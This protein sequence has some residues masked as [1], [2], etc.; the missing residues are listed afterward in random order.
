MASALLDL[1][2]EILAVGTKK[3]SHEDEEKVRTILGPDVRLIEDISPAVI[4]R[5]FAE[6]GADLLVAG[7]R[8]RYLAAKEGWPFIDVNQ[9]REHAYA[10]YEGLVQVARDLHESVRFYEAQA[11]A[12]VDCPAPAQPTPV[13]T[14]DRS[15]VIDPLKNAPTVGAILALQGI[16][17][18][19]P[20]LHAAQG[21][22]FLGKVLMIR[23]FNEPIALATTKLF[24]EEV[25][26][27][28]DEAAE[29][30]V[31]SFAEKPA[32]QR[33]ELIALVSGA[34]AEVKGDDVDALA[35]RLD[36]E[37]DPQGRRDSRA[38][39]TTVASKRATPPQSH[40]LAGLA[41]DVEPAATPR[42]RPHH[43]P[44]GAHLTP[45]DAVWLARARRGVRPAAGV[46]ARTWAPSTAAELGLSALASD[47]TSL[48]EIHGTRVQLTHARAR[49]LARG[50]RACAARAFRHAVLGARDARTVSPPPTCC[51][52]RSRCSPAPRCRCASSASAACSSTPCAT[53]SSNS[54]ARR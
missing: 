33:P 37:L 8:N 47:G 48:A 9:E 12:T 38:P 42:S 20:V 49:R 15:A 36:A 24:T 35:R 16:D 53:P 31:R 32:G 29:K 19:L 43:R 34:L 54:P 52:P 4:R 3:S 17:A 18:T 50:D 11:A 26:L 22:S 14:E 13:R 40:A 23:H 6:E 46:P 10:G 51:S 44:R 30:I 1:G 21:C 2:I 7:G 45:G 39:T 5:L 41:R 25:V 28:S 27:G